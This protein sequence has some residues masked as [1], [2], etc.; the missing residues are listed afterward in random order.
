MKHCI[1]LTGLRPA[2]YCKHSIR[3]SFSWAAIDGVPIELE[4]VLVIFGST[5]NPLDYSQYTYISIVISVPIK[6]CNN[7]FSKIYY[8]MFQSSFIF[9]SISESN[10]CRAL[11]KEI[12][13][14]IHIVAF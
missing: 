2:V 14:N 12:N 10:I 1:L 6:C 13:T 4:I 5:K 8:I 9:C 3:H 7:T 11:K